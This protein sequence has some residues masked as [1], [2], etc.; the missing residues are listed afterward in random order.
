MDYGKV[1]SRAWQITWRWKV[2]WILGFLA[3]LGG[4]GG[5]GSSYSG[6]GKEW[7]TSV[8]RIPTEIW[9]LIIAAVCVAILVGIALWVISIIARGGLIAGVQQIEDEGSTTFLQ[10][11]RVG[12]KRF[13]TLF[14]INI[15]VTI[16]IL[17]LVIASV[18]IFVAGMGGTGAIAASR[19]EDTMW[20]VL[21][22][23]ILCGGTLCCGTL[24]VGIVLSVVQIYAE[25]AAILEGLGWIE[26]LKRGWQVIKA[27]IGPTIIFWLIFLVIGLVIGAIVL[28]GVMV[29][30]MPFIAFFTRAKP[31][32][33]IIAP[34]CCSGL[35]ATILS[36]LIGSIA[37][38][39]TSAT[40]TLAY[41][42]MIGREARPAIETVAE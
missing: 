10:A 16:P 18:A 26:A 29:L 4:G 34:V 24:L 11:W 35:L 17:I 23:T 5:G 30:I 15:L 32:A 28:G 3:S 38:T 25:R 20:A 42:E 19:G 7:S 40:W 14:G 1:L 9:V 21:L 13:W 36:A 12:R 31:E 33:W 27:N 8:D 37:Q 2:L 41:R 39:F 6:N 22:P